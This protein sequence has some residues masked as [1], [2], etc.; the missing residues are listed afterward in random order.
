MTPEEVA[1][2]RRLHDD[3]IGTDAFVIGHGREAREEVLTASRQTAGGSVTALVRCEGPAAARRI[4]EIVL[5][6]D[7]FVAPPRV[8]LDLEA[9]LRGV[10]V[11]DAGAEVERFL[12]AAGI[13]MLSIRA[14]DF[15]AVVADALSRDGAAPASAGGA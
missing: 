10:A 8:V 6:G 12:A 3:E 4:R 11:A 9:H 2:T 14:A 13:A 1:L 7:F 5:A 15:A